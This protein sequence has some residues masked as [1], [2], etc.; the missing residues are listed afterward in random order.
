MDNL[1]S[2]TCWT[3]ALSILTWSE[4]SAQEY[5]TKFSYSTGAT[6]IFYCSTSCCGTLSSRYCCFFSL[7]TSSIAGIVVGCLILVAV[8]LAIVC[9]C[10]KKNGSRGR[11]VQ[12]SRI[13]ISVLPTGNHLQPQGYNNRFNGPAPPGYYNGNQPVQTQ[14]GFYN[15]QLG[16]VHFNNG[17]P[18]MQPGFNDKGPFGPTQQEYESSNPTGMVQPAYPPSYPSDSAHSYN[19]SGIPPPFPYVNPESSGIQGN[20]VITSTSVNNYGNAQ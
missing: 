17:Q 12:P 7:G 19:G 1:L 5:C 20:S 10:V 9:M 4:A 2:S 16:T 14:N 8:T 18:A 13:K 6:K 15:N 11:V 3:F